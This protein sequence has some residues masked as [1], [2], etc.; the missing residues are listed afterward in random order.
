ME[1][2]TSGMVLF[3]VKITLVHGTFTSKETKDLSLSVS[4]KRWFRY[5]GYL[6]SILVFPR[7]IA[8]LSVTQ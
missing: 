2:E 4:D 3:L 5:T 8:V 7:Q 1:T 6:L